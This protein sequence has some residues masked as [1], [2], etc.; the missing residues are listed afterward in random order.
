MTKKL[1]KDYNRLYIE[2]VYESFLYTL[3]KPRDW[4]KKI[5]LV[6]FGLLLTWTLV[7]IQR[8]Q[9][10]SN[11]N[12]KGTKKKNQVSNVNIFEQKDPSSFFCFPQWQPW[13]FH[14]QTTRQDSLCEGCPCRSLLQQWSPSNVPLTCRSPMALMKPSGKEM[15]PFHSL[16]FFAGAYTNCKI[17]PISAFMQIDRCSISWG[18]TACPWLIQA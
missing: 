5:P 17:C 15:F 2:K 6:F 14:K 10:V 12:L 1:F 8:I 16:I 13:H 11:M 4:H 7:K 18:Q 9:E 3:N